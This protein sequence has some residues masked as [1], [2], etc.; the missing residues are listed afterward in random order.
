M[1]V[2][3]STKLLDDSRGSRGAILSWV[4]LVV[5]SVAGLAVNAAVGEPT[6]TGWVMTAWPS[7]A[8][9]TANELLMR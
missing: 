8:L 7:F 1:I 2:A 5:G 3:T 4:L 9:V 6:P